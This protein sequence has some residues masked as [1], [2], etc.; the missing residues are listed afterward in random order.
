VI[1]YS[2]TLTSK[3]NLVLIVC[4]VKNMTS[5]CSISIAQIISLY[6]AESALKRTTPMKDALLLIFM[7]LKRCAKC[8]DWISRWIKNNSKKEK[9]GQIRVVSIKK[10]RLIKW[11]E[12]R[13]GF[14]KEELIKFKKCSKN[15]KISIRC[16]ILNKLCFN[17]RVNLLL[18]KMDYLQILKLC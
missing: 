6:F 17:H 3:T 4:Y 9:T 13:N 7:K 11:S 10:F 1:T 12:I 2:G 14:L 15:C 16:K 18:A 8:I 5:G